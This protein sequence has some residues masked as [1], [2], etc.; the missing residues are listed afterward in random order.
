MSM[1]EKIQSLES[2]LKHYGLNNYCIHSVNGK[3]AL[4]ELYD[5]SGA[6]TVTR[7]MTYNEFNTWLFKLNR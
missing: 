2:V 3:F 6:I 4:A 7:F 1:K 5:G